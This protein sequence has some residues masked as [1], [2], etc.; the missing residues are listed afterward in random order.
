MDVVVEAEEA[1]VVELD[2][3]VVAVTGTAAAAAALWEIFER[4]EEIKKDMIINITV[5]RI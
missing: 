1:G 3:V 4:V 2:G 5:L